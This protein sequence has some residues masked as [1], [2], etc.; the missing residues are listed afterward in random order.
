MDQ[1]TQSRHSVSNCMACAVQHSKLQQ[2]MP[3]RPVF[4]PENKE[5]FNGPYKQVSG[6]Q[7]ARAHFDKINPLCLA[8]T[9]KPFAAVAVNDIDSIKRVVNC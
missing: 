4:E 8:L 3:M 2:S 7:F 9:G 1:Q 5:N 6:K